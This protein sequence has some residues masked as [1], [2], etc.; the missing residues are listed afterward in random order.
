MK[1]LRKNPAMVATLISGLLI[2]LGWVLKYT[3][4]ETLTTFIFLSSFIIGG[5][6]QAKEG[7]IDTIQTK[8]LNVDILMVLA[9]IGASIIGYWME[10]ALLIFIFSLSGSLEE[11][12]TNKSTEAIASLMNM[13]SETALKIQMDGVTKEVPIE[14]LS[15][16]DLVFVP[17]GASIPIDGTIEKGNGLIDE[18][19]ISGEPLPVEKTIG[20]DV[21]GGTI[22]LGEGI[23]LKVSKDVKDTLFAKIIRLVEE[24]QNTPS[25][26]ASM[27]KKI[28]STYVKIVL[29]L[30][31]V[32][33]AVFY[34]GLH[35]GWNESFY[36]GMVLLVVASPC[37]LVASATP[38]TL[39][40]I[41]NGAKHGVLF[42]GVLIWRTLVK[43]KPLLLIR[44][45][46]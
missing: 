9:A 4:Q 24:A 38:A 40:A 3:S 43:L 27:I 46:L 7:F 21:F 25:K 23:T 45:E 16:S 44:L 20:E 15:I 19:A 39:A 2:L 31:P 5:F 28:E 22:N 42:K 18:A 34:F 17:K 41:S 30:V 1:L 10:G 32:M 13:Q 12:A 11:Y 8:K 33:I 35:W 36:R 37:A 29:T 26:T 14:S 6:K